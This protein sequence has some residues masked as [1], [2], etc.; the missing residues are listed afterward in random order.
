MAEILDPLAAYAKF[1]GY[2][3]RSRIILVE[4]TRDADSFLLRPSYF[5]RRLA[6]I[7]WRT[8][9]SFRREKETVEESAE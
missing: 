9:L 1:K 3:V 2:P 7:L 5:E 6:P 8:S 4:G